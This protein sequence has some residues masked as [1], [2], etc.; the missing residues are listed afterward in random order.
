MP[1]VHPETEEKRDQLGIRA[2]RST[3]LP[4]SAKLL[5]RWWGIN[6]DPV[7][8]QGP[9]LCSAGQGE[10][11]QPP[12]WQANRTSAATRSL[13]RKLPADSGP[14]WSKDSTKTSRRKSA[15]R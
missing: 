5:S 13:G 7:Q 1:G 3:S 14:T 9:F 8:A 2:E 12:R 10:G 4:R 15:P 11:S 6:Y